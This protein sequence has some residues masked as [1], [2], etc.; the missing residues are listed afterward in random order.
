M[1]PYRLLDPGFTYHSAASHAAGSEAFRERQRERMRL[2]QKAQ[3][4]NVRPI[5]RKETK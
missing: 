3:P 1:K 5:K 4:A 2:A